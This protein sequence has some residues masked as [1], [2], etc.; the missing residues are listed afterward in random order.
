MAQNG[1]EGRQKISVSRALLRIGFLLA[2]MLFLFA[3]LQA[4]TTTV[5]IDSP[6]PVV[7]ASFN[8]GDS[9]TIKAL[10][11][12]SDAGEA[13]QGEPLHITSSTGFSAVV[14]TYSVLQT[15]TFTA[16]AAGTISAFITHADGDESATITVVTFSAYA[17]GY[18]ANAYTAGAP[19]AQLRLTNDGDTEGNLWANIYVFN[20]DEEMEE[21]CSCVVTP[22]GYLDLDV[23][24]DLTSNPVGGG[25]AP[26]RGII[27][28]VSSSVP[29]P[30]STYA[31]VSGIRGWLT[32]IQD[33]T[34]A[35]SFSITESDLKDSN[36]SASEL[37]ISL[38]ETCSFLLSLGGASPACSCTDAGH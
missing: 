33:L 28:V 7:I 18:F 13:S 15:F 12:S 16:P 23:N 29:G 6:S 1:S 8:L 22:N 20:N 5:T 10:L 9:V 4:V 25:V 35:T 3:P 26:K 36:L 24:G 38:Q 31:P 30:A 14:S 32:Q 21:C 11:V 19:D 37:R 2:G 17:V 27:R 34:T